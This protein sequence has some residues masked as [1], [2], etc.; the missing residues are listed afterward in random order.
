MSAR[1]V[2]GQSRSYLASDEAFRFVKALHERNL[3]I[4]VV[5]D[6]GT[7]EGAI[8]RVGDYVRGHGSRVSGFYGSNVQTYLSNE[9]MIAFCRSLAALPHDQDRSSFI[10]IGGTAPFRQK[11]A[12]CTR[13][14]ITF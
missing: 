3:I 9:K 1:D 10:H 11:L 12:S 6:F 7:S 8:A 13:R 14:A 4:P 5:G 2:S